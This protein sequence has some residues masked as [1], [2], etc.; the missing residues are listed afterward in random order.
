MPQLDINVILLA[1]CGL[2]LFMMVCLVILMLLLRSRNSDLREQLHT[3]DDQMEDG[4]RELNY[5]QSQQAMAQ[6]EET[7]RAIQSV[8]DSVLGNVSAATQTQL[9]QLSALQKQSAESSQAQ[10]YRQHR[11]NQ[12][13]AESLAKF[14][15]RMQEIETT[16]DQK[17]LQNENRLEKMRLTLE[18][19]I[20]KLQTENSQKLDEMR[21]TVDEK[22]HD[23]L[24]KRLGESFTQVSQRLEQVYQSLGEMHSLAAGVGDLKRVLTNV[25]TRGTWGEMQL[26]SLLEQVLTPAQYASN[27][28]VKPGSQE[29]VEFAVCLP[30]KDAHSDQPVY[31]PIDSK[32]PQEDYARLADASE[33]GDAQAVDAAQK[34]LLAALRVEAKRIS[35]K[36]I[37]PPYTTDFAVMFLPMEGLYAEI[38][39]HSDVAEQ[40]QREQRVVMAGPSTLMALLN[41]LQMGFRTLAIEQRSAE[42]WKLLGAVKTDFGSFA[43]VLQKTQEKLQQASSTID[44]AFVRT[45]SIERKLR[46]VE[47]MDE[48]HAALLLGEDSG[49]ETP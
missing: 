21:K 39:R 6:R 43:Q 40:I 42:V 28:A 35:G 17:L 3:L 41:S 1:M 20:N 32:F 22:L 44:S 37:A 16:L 8:G 30:G 11:L 47:A 29:R 13:T 38:M 34:A 5:Q 2:L 12:T 15:Q 7:L 31:L 9:S 27:V 14:E 10:E 33:T 36:Y 25:K 4:L 48:Q 19:G 45:R 49:E 18:G 23:T 26:G 24:N 46:R